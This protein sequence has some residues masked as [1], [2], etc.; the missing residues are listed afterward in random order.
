MRVEP[1]SRL[2]SYEILGPLG[3]GGMGE[4]WRARDTRLQ[5]EVALKILP[6][7]FSSDAERL[8]RFTREAHVLA[9]LNHPGIAAIYSFEEIEG[10]NFLALELV[11]GETLK[12]RIARGPIPLSE[13]LGF[14]RQI[15][16]ALE[17]AHGKG[18][19]HRDLKPAN[20]MV[21][22]DGRVKLLDF[23][24][25]KAFAA[26]QASQ[27]ISESPTAAADGTKQG[28]ILGTASYMSPE[29]AR[30]RTLDARSDL[31]ALGCLLY[32]MLVGRKAATQTGTP[33]PPRP[34]R[35]SATSFR[36]FSKRAST[37]DGGTC[38]T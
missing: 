19:L 11:P 1:G 28:L 10:T 4:V 15:A 22:P 16:E 12:H 21:T 30:G 26:E 5:R 18:I 36:D 31:W 32:E 9:S 8:S 37:E 25:A 35:P 17:A 27:D 29:Q 6:E 3:A 14:A 34:R 33:C 7:A 20:V 24:L 23:G 38:A 2:G 13:A